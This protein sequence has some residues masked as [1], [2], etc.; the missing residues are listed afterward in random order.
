MC[1]E[2]GKLLL[3][4]CLLFLHGT[5]GLAVVGKY[6]ALQVVGLVDLALVAV[7]GEIVINGHVGDIVEV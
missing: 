2:V 5:V 1:L 6:A 4:A 7:E 3:N